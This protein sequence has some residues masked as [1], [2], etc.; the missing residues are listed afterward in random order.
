MF[1]KKLD[2]D[3]LD[4]LMYSNFLFNPCVGAMAGAPG[5][6]FEACGQPAGHWSKVQRGITQIGIN[7]W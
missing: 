6:F 3:K 1:K 4:D 2:I 5:L 7:A